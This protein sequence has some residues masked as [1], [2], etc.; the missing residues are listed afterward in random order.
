MKYLIVEFLGVFF[1][2]LLTGLANIMV[3]RD[4]T[5]IIAN[6]FTFGLLI[7][8]FSICSKNVSQGLFNPTFAIVQNLFGELTTGATIGY[9]ASHVVASLSATSLLS[10]VLDFNGYLDRKDLNLGV[11]QINE[12]S[13]YFSVFTVEIIGCVF[14]YLG[15][16]FFFVNKKGSH[17]L[18][19][20]FYGFLATAL[21]LATYELSGGTYNISMI[22]GGILY[23][24]IINNKLIILFIGNIF[25][26]VISRL[27][28]QRI[29]VG[30][31]DT[32]EHKILKLLFS[33]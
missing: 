8:I 16:L 32:K 18:G 24:S 22:L 25:G 14:L 23:D 17:E 12:W 13:D 31:E 21:Y 29:L 3:D 28:Y 27:L 30:K 20:L 11:K 1:M 15:Y 19:S 7:M 6:S 33:N 9:I 10:S 4:E 26:V 5:P 2:V